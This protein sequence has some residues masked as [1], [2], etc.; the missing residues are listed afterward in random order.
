MLW[1]REGLHN[2]EEARHTRSKLPTMAAATTTEDETAAVSAPTT[3][4]PRRMT[5]LLIMVV[6][7]SVYGVAYGRNPNH[8][9]HQLSIS[10]NSTTYATTTTGWA[11]SWDHGRTTPR[12][13]S[14]IRHPL[15]PVSLPSDDDD[16][17][18]AAVAAIAAVKAAKPTYLTPSQRS[19]TRILIHVGKAGGLS[20]QDLAGQARTR[21]DGEAAMADAADTAAAAAAAADGATW[22]ATAVVD[23]AVVTRRQLCLLAR[24]PSHINGGIVHMGDNFASV[25]RCYSG[26]GGDGIASVAS[27]VHRQFVVT[28]RNPVDRL[29]SWFHYEKELYYGKSDKWRA[30]FGG[31]NFLRLVECYD[32]DFGKLLAGVA[33]IL[34]PAGGHSNDG[35]GEN[36]AAAARAAAVETNRTAAEECRTL[37]VRCLK[38]DA[39]CFSHNYYNYEVYLEELLVWKGA[40]DRSATTTADVDINNSTSDDGTDGSRSSTS[41]TIRVDVI[42]SEHSDDDLN[43]TIRLWSGYAMTDQVSRLYGRLNTIKAVTVSTRGTTSKNGENNSTNWKNTTNRKKDTSI[44]K[45]NNKWNS[46]YSKP[47]SRRHLQPSTTK[48]ETTRTELYSQGSIRALCRLICIELVVYKKILQVADNLDAGQV[49]DSHKYLDDRCGFNVDAVC[50]T[51]FHYR[52]VKSQKRIPISLAKDKIKKNV[53]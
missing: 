53:N 25:G 3:P 46:N 12:A 6:A 43:R 31:P 29:I 33:V 41:T 1:H 7:M 10:T 9:L 32:G 45:H 14:P 51:Q 39:A 8:L 47:T 2:D 21:C 5:R 30:H 35:G 49:A 42:R 22:N 36:E 23:D 17:D 4:T 19:E 50:G 48:K 40:A 20:F 15:P 16:D 24:I 26:G 28:V 44:W 11:S 18:D 34:P 13:A 52:N 38:G 27:P 37:A